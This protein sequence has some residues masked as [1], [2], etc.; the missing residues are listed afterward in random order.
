MLNVP[1]TDDEV[2][3]LGLSVSRKANGIAD[4]IGYPDLQTAHPDAMEN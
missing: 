1:E 3:D 4:E 2:V